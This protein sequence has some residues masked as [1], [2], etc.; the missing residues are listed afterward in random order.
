M[1]KDPFNL[2]PQEYFDSRGND[3][4]MWH[5]TAYY[6]LKA[7]D[8]LYREIG[9]PPKYNK[10]VKLICDWMYVHGIA[11]MLR[12][13]AIECLFKALWLHYGGV[14]VK[15]GK[16]RGIPEAKDHDLFSIYNNIYKKCNLNLTH[17]ELLMLS[18]FSFAIT[19][20]RYPIQRSFTCSYPSAPLADYE[21]KWNKVEYQKDKNIFKRI[22][23]EIENQLK[24]KVKP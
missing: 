13:M 1:N 16:Y 18:R 17:E 19:N 4:S 8:I 22:I 10:N 23:K 3:E 6:L 20:G 5:M 7:A 21:V 15:N 11:R 2:Q 12:G 14:L 24:A 9:N